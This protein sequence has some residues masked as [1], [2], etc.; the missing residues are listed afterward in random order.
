M[1]IEDLKHELRKLGASSF[2]F[3][4]L[5]E[6]DNSKQQIYLGGSYEALQKL[7]YSDIYAEQG[8]KR[9]T[10]KANLDF[11]W[12][13]DDGNLNKA[14]HA[15]LILYPKYPEI[16]LSG[17]LNGC[18]NA[19]SKYL[20]PIPKENRMGQYD[21]RVLIL[22]PIESKI[23]AYLAPANSAVSNALFDRDVQGVFGE[24]NLIKQDPKA[25][26]LS[27]LHNVYNTNPHAPVR[28]FT[29]GVIRP[30][31]KKN[32]AGYTL[33]AQFGIIP[34][35]SPDPDFMGWEL[36][37]F[38]K[39]RITLMTPQPNAGLYAQM[40]PKEFVKEYGHLTDKGDIYFTGPYT[41]EPNENFFDRHLKIIGFDFVSSKIT[42]PDGGIYLL[43]NDKE[44][45]CW[46]F[47]HILSHWNHKHNKACYVRYKTT[48]SK[49]LEFQSNVLLCEGTS[50]IHL[51]KALQENII[52]FDP[53]SKVT[54]EGVSKQRSQFRINF[55]N[56]SHIYEK[57]ELYDVSKDIEE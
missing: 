41:T 51:L 26:L 37:G 10:F 29:D 8:L 3:K 25:T 27:V 23:I 19:P 17:F 43:E 30:Y 38:N 5:A 34:N 45:A 49:Q 39:S 16:R 42:Q 32:A 46:S 56:L 21:G 7:P 36:K 13:G 18:K 11:Y 57:T 48:S 14:P 20:Q 33:E 52:C 40:G 47:S 6:N 35:G 24:E 9:P 22:C 4:K 28:L 50:A 2:L 1:T 44:L 31:N 53:G 55:N 12:L 54:Q 15:K